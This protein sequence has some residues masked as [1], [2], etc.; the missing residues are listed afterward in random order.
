MDEFRGSNAGYATMEQIMEMIAREIRSDRELF[1]GHQVTN[2][3]LDKLLRRAQDERKTL[4]IRADSLQ[5][6]VRA[7]CEHLQHQKD[8][9]GDIVKSLQ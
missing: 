4:Q 5:G 8:V 3:E 6:E 2:R 7:L 1:E 9:I